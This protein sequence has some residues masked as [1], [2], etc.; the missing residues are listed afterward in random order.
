MPFFAESAGDHPGGCTGPL[1]G[2]GVPGVGP[3]QDLSNGKS[4]TSHGSSYVKRKNQGQVEVVRLLLLELRR[5]AVS[6]LF[7]LTKTATD[8]CVPARCTGLVWA[9]VSASM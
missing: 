7:S 9:E 4:G 5:E 3:R 8:N 6:V 2:T 1:P